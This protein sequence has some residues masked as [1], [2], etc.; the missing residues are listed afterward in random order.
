MVCDPREISEDSFVLSVKDG[1]NLA[2]AENLLPMQG[3][4]TILL[5]LSGGPDSTALLAALIPVAF[6]NGIELQ[7][8]HVNHGLRGEESDDDEQFCRL[9]CQKWQLPLHVERLAQSSRSEA[10]LRDLRYER[11]QSVAEKIGANICLTGH[12]ADDQVETMLF[13]LFRGTGPAG[14]LGIPACRRISENL[15]VLRPM[16]SLTRI[17][18]LSYLQRLNLC[19]RYDSS[20]ED[21][22]YSR[23]FIRNQVLPLV[24]TRFRG[25]RN[26]IDQLRRVMEA[27]ES[28][29]ACMSKDALIELASSGDK[30]LWCLER[31][32]ELPLSLRR[33]VLLE[34]FRQRRVQA[35]FSRLEAILEMIDTDGESAITLNEEWELRLKNGTLRW[36]N[37]LD[38]P[39][40]DVVELSVPIHEQGMTLI[41]KLG[42]AVRVEK[43]SEE[44]ERIALPGSQEHELVGDLTSVGQ[45]MVRLREAGD[46]IQPL[47]MSCMVRL[48]KYLHT[49]KSTKTL[50]FGGRVL[51]LANANEVL[52]VPGCGMSQRIA[53]GSKAT[54][55]I[56]LMKIAADE[57]QIC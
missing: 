25:V 42:L 35:D 23:N 8:C 4:K 3:F 10:S 53:I 57:N 37:R 1:L 6:Q 48:K 54:H 5:A 9:L 11:L 16:L 40:D 14:F 12:T 36:N 30:N 55:R 28:L 29:L 13:R 21:D 38:K 2:L 33:R 45:L 26:H 22:S 46:Q 18:C 49:H 56:S 51:V 7:A 15:V 17:D 24:E 32:D 19:A 31:F 27:D 20:N 41:H 39:C 47:G 50:S 52:W 43:V 34:A 44:P